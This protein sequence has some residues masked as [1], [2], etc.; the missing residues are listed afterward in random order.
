MNKKFLENL[1][2]TKTEAI[3]DS[4][5]ELHDIEQEIEEL[6][7]NAEYIKTQLG[8]DKL[9]LNTLNNKFKYITGKDVPD[10][11]RK[12]NLVSIYA[13]TSSETRPIIT[14]VAIYDTYMMACNGYYAVRFKCESIPDNLKNTLVNWEKINELK[15]S[16]EFSINDYVTFLDS[17]FKEYKEK[18]KT[19]FKITAEAFINSKVNDTDKD[20]S[21]RPHSLYNP[22]G[23]IIGLN[24]DYLNLC[25]IPFGDDEFTVYFTDKNSP[26]L[27]EKGD[28]E[29]ILLPVKFLEK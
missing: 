21:D 26:I 13:E 10:Y 2:E 16:N 12:F 17:M 29:V 25:L 23:N 8:L 19:N 24:R 18:S 9:E 20:E 27:F 7:D 4:E 1:I 11:I 5:R 22:N 14:N 6:K 28:Y 15:P 3:E